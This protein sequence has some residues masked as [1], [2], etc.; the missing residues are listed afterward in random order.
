[1]RPIRRPRRSFFTHDDLLPRQHIT[2]RPHAGSGRGIGHGDRAIDPHLANNG[3]QKHRR[4]VHAVGNHHHPSQPIGRQH[5]LDDVIVPMK[6]EWAAVAQMCK[7]G[8]ARVDGSVQYG[9]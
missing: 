3:S 9:Q 2:A 1:M 8:E 7:A 6:H 4:Q 5:T